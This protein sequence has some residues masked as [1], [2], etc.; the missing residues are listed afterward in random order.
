MRPAAPVPDVVLEIVVPPEM[1]SLSVAVIVTVPASPTP[2]VLV[3]ISDPP[4]IVNRSAC[5]ATS[6]AL[7]KPCTT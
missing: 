6:P 5:S 1:S 4:D 2:K 3:L 7:I